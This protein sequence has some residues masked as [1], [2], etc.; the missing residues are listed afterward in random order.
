MRTEERAH[1]TGKTFRLVEE[2]DRRVTPGNDDVGLQEAPPTVVMSE[3]VGYIRDPQA[4]GVRLCPSQESSSN[5]LSLLSRKQHPTLPALSAQV[6]SVT[7]L[8]SLEREVAHGATTELIL[9]I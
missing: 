5:L 2:E 8:S 3:A 4:Q 6:G 1:E 7:S 9:G